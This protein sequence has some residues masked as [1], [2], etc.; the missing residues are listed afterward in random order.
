MLTRSTGA[1]EAIKD[2][3]LAI[4]A[5]GKGRRKQRPEERLVTRA[6]TAKQTYTTH[7]K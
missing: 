6:N 5:W 2:A 3:V 1:R 4:M 7:T